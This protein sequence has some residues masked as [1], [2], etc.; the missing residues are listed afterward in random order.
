MADSK[1]WFSFL[2]TSDSKSLSIDYLEAQVQQVI[3]E[4]DLVHIVT[5]QEQETFDWVVF[6]S[7]ADDT[8]KLIQNPSADERD[9]LG[10]FDYQDNFMVVHRDTSIMPK[11]Q[12]QWASWHVHVTAQENLKKIAKLIKYTMDLLTG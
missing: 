9:V 2:Y 4:N 1:R 12:S 3:R 10:C 11:R 6:A 5:N 8:L 7:H